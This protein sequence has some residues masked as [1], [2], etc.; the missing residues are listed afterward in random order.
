MHSGVL[1]TIQDATPFPLHSGAE[2]VTT[3]VT[4]P[5]KRMLRILD[6]SEKSSVELR[7][8]LQNLG[9]VGAV[10]KAAIQLVKVQPYQL[11]ASDTW[12]LGEFFKISDP[13][14]I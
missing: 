8:I 7:A 4:D 13:S 12:V 1:S 6:D 5:V 3:E 14:S 10:N 11:P 9:D 2:K